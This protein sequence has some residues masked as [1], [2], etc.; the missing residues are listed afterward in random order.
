MRY[1]TKLPKERV[2]VE[3]KSEVSEEEDRR[4]ETRALLQERHFG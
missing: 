2:Q 1:I 4:K 3:V